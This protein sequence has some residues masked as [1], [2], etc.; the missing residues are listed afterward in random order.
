MICEICKTEFS[1]IRSLTTHIT[2]GHRLPLKLYY[3]VYLKG[4]NG[5]CHV[6]N[7]PTTFK[8][9]KNGYLK[10]CSIECS[11]KDSDVIQKR[12]QTTLKRYGNENYR[13]TAKTKKTNMERY[14]VKNISQNS[15]VNIKRIQNL[16]NKY[17]E[18]IIQNSKIL[19]VNLLEDFKSAHTNH[20]WECLKCK[21]IFIQRWNRIQQGFTCKICNPRN[22]SSYELNLRKFLD[23]LNVSYLMNSR[24]VI[25][26]Y[27]LDIF[28]PSHNIAIE[29]NG[30]YWHS[31]KYKDENYHLNKLNLC[32]EKNIN[33]IQIFEDEWLHK[34]DI[35][36]SKLRQILKKNEYEIID[37]KDCQIKKISLKV[38]NNF[39][40]K[41]DIQG[42]DSSSVNLG[43]FY[44]GELISVMTFSKTKNDVFELKRLCSISKY[45][46]KGIAAKLL[47]YF[48]KNYKWT[49]IFSYVDRR[50]LDKNLY[51]KLGF[52]FNE[53]TRPDFWY[54]TNT[55]RIDKT[56]SRE[57]KKSGCNLNRIWDC[58]KSKGIVKFTENTGSIN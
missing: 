32:K 20:K 24:D 42:K 49:E 53:N 46:V 3:D 28:I 57:F 39:L 37:A 29:V 13:N 9:L 33:L 45:R 16:K 23:D 10:Y 11:V 54:T 50:W 47:V 25:P 27:E 58:G 41:Y 5:F 12:K 2:K 48:K 35:V 30:L 51:E 40:E 36:K 34:Q 31:E 55:K 38:K 15:T 52:D 19:N 18:D 26:P 44:D 4:D 7:L 56:K 21:N 1:K 6:C 14:G 8:N 43:V 17:K 22:Q